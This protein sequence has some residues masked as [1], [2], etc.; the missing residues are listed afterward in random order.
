MYCTYVYEMMKLPYEIA[1]AL[2]GVVISLLL[3]Y[4]FKLF[5]IFNRETEREQ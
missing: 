5:T 1:Q 3:C 2:L 4:R